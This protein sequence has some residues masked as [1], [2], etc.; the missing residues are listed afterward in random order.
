[1]DCIRFEQNLTKKNCDD[2]SNQSKGRAI[3]SPPPDGNHAT[4]LEYDKLIGKATDLPLS[5]S[6]RDKMS[7]DFVVERFDFILVVLERSHLRRGGFR[8]LNAQASN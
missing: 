8:M 5:C 1:M 6:H 3:I 7:V 4:V 2:Y